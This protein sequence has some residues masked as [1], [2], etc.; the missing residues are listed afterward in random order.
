MSNI[1][2]RFFASDLID[3]VMDDLAWGFVD[4]CHPQI[5]DYKFHGRLVDTDKFDITPKKDYVETLIRHKQEQIDQNDR[6]HEA[7]NRYYEERRKRLEEEKERLLRD[8]DNK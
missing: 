1:R 8:R 5:T 3:E 6:D 4:L 2:K 7:S